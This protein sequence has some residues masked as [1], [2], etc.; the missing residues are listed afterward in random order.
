MVDL[1]PTELMHDGGTN[2]NGVT[3]RANVDGY[4]TAI[5][6]YCEANESGTRKAYIWDVETKTV[7]ASFETEITTTSEGWYQFDLPTAVAITANKLYVYP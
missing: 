6:V 4:I 7:V 5:R 2:Q 1:K 3:I